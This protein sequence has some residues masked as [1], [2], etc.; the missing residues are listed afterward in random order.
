MDIGAADITK[1]QEFWAT[2]SL[3]ALTVFLLLFTIYEF[4]RWRKA[5]KY[6]TK[7]VG[8]RYEAGILQRFRADTSFNPVLEFQ[9]NGVIVRQVIRN[10][11][12]FI[13]EG[14]LLKHRILGDKIIYPLFYSTLLMSIFFMLLL[15]S[16]INPVLTHIVS[17]HTYL[18]LL[19]GSMLLSFFTAAIATINK[20]T[21]NPK[22]WSYTQLRKKP[23][24][25]E[26]YTEDDLDAIERKD[27]VSYNDVLTHHHKRIKL[28][29][30]NLVI[31]YAFILIFVYA[32]FFM[33]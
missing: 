31:L 26:Q 13:P 8:Y 23:K 15:G 24:N 27:M 19:Y 16:I 3:V 12:L 33:K 18:T 6:T 29:I 4:Y 11:R 14:H 1:W 5:S 22:Y 9:D 25:L 2:F 30:V 20:Y 32:Q 28:T 10:I 7:I 17:S 21:F